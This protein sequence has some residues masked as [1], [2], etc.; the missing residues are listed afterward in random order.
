VIFRWRDSRARHLR[1]AS[2]KSGRSLRIPC[3]TAVGI[4]AT[5]GSRPD[6]EGF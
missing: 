3:E 1:G 6:L 4:G 2:R 5:D